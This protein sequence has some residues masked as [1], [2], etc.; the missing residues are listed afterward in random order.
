MHMLKME[1]TI[2]MDT[3]KAANFAVYLAIAFAK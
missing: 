1:K 3:L 2:Q